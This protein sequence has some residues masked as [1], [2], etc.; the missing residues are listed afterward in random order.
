MASL[1]VD[2]LF[3]NIALDEAVNIFVLFE[4]ETQFESFKNF[5]NTCHPKMKFTFEKEQS[6]CFNFLDV[7]EKTMFL[8]PPFTVNSLLV[9]FTRILIVTRYRIISLF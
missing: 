9:V 2:S 1:D 3:I 8:P 5:M 7:S 6:N 4:S